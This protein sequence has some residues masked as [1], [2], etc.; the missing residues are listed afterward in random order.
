MNPWLALA[1]L[2]VPIIY[3]ARG[4]RRST[5]MDRKSIRSIEEHE[6]HAA[7]FAYLRKKKR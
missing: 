4:K 1:I 5:Y 3:S 6:D 2:V 7:R